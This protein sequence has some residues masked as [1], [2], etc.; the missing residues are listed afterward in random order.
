MQLAKMKTDPKFVK[1][2][3]LTFLLKKQHEEEEEDTGTRPVG[4]EMR[5]QTK[6]KKKEK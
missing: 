1:L 2:T 6:E 4:R 3:R 5:D